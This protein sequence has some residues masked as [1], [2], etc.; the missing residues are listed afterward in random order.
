MIITAK[1][2]STQKKPYPSATFF[3]SSLE[4]VGLV[5]N[6]ASAVKGQQLTT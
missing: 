4:L 2:Y 5:L 6:E 1:S 3:T